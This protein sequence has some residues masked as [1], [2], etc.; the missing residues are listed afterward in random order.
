MAIGNMNTIGAY[1]NV[2]TK[3]NV[4][5]ECAISLN[6]WRLVCVKCQRT[7]T[8]EEGYD[9]E[10]KYFKEGL[11]DSNIQKFA[12]EHRHQFE[13]KAEEKKIEPGQSQM[14]KEGRKFR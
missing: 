12:L 2:A 4:F 5:A 11:L 1:L 13:D 3:G 6:R 8:L 9:L 10:Q 14:K 7:M